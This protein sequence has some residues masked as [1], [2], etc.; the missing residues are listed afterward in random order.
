MLRG[1]VQTTLCRPRYEWRQ[2]GPRISWHS[3]P[4]LSWPA[5]S[6]QTTFAQTHDFLAHFKSYFADFH[7]FG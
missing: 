3:H 2:R 5:V 1:Q 7:I 6:I 4:A